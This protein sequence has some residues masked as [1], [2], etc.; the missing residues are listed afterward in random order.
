[1]NARMKWL[2]AA[3]S[4]GLLLAAPAGAGASHGPKAGPPQDFVTG[5]AKALPDTPFALTR[6]ISAHSGPLGEDPHGHM[7]VTE[8]F[9]GHFG[10]RVTCLS[11]AGNTASIGIEVVHAENPALV[12]TGFVVFIVDLG[13]PVEGQ[14]VDQFGG[15][16][17][18][19][20]PAVC[21]PPTPPALFPIESG[22]YVVHDGQPR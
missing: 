20:P 1:M 10:G 4:V 21:P 3:L 18:P 15:S 11:V 8:S 12:G 14:G 17:T 19:T 2:L 5:G 6:N 22:N 13:E 16:P 7:E 9:F